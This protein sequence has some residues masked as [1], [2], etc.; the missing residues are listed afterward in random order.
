MVVPPNIPNSSKSLDRLNI[1]TIIAILGILH[2]KKFQE[3]PILV[4]HQ[5]IEK[6]PL[7]YGTLNHWD[8]FYIAMTCVT[9]L[10]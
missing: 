7:V 9:W 2:V 4:G 8:K 1:D 6:L 5:E 3:T 10:S